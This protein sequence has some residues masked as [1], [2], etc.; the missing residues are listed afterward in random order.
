M[1]ECI[2]KSFGLEAP[3][4]RELVARDGTTLTLIF[5]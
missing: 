1:T 5:C 2:Q 3:A 4:G